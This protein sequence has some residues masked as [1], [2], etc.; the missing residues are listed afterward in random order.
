MIDEIT[1]KNLTTQDEIVI[2]KTP[3]NTF[4]LDTDG[5]DWG[6]VPGNHSTY[7]NL[8]GVGNI[9]TSTKIDTRDVSVTGVVCSPRTT[10]QIAEY[11]GVSTLDEIAEKKLKEIEEAKKHISQLL[12]PVD[13]IR[14][15]AGKYWIQGKPSSSVEFASTWAENNEILCHFTFSLYCNDPMFYLDKVRTEALN[16]LVGGYHFPIAIPKPNGMHF[17]VLLPYLST[18]ID[19]EGD[20]SVGAIFYIEAEGNV[21]EVTFTNVETQEFMRVEK[22]LEAGQILRID[23]KNR[24]VEFSADKGATYES[25][26]SAWDFN[27]T[28]LQFPV[29]VTAINYS[30][31][32]KSY[33][34][35]RIWVELSEAFYSIGAQ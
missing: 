11:Y 22:S 19:N 15:T 7:T 4:M 33:R 5:I 27:S 1:I 8:I 30:T 21:S 2:S 24:R 29:G 13:F 25:I 23:T 9:I 10:K 17:G 16:G 6:S 26:L 31:T 34:N 14:I 32:D 28:W 12:N 18:E 20:N 35:A 3:R